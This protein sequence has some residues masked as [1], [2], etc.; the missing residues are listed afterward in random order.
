VQAN[1]VAVLVEPGPQGRPLADQGLVGDLGRPLAEGHEP[2]LGEPLEQRL[3]HLG[4]D[5]VGDELVDVHAPAAFG[6]GVAELREPEEHA[7]RHGAAVGRQGGEHAVGGARDRRGDAA[8]LAVAL[9]GERASV[10]ALPGGAERVREERQR[11]G[12]AGDVAQGQLDQPGLEPQP[13]EAC[14]LSHR[15]LELGVAHRSEQHLV[16]GDRASE[17]RVR[18][19]LA[20]HVGSHADRDRSPDRQQRIDECLPARG[21]VAQREQLLELIDDHKRGRIVGDVEPR[22]PAR[23]DQGSA[24]DAVDFAR[25]HGGDDAGSK[26]R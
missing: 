9:D 3:H 16:G 25:P 18:S 6:C 14:R 19:E 15:S 22:R 2:R 7:A 13:G 11:P 26:Q 23:P 1:A 17:L 20:V 24:C 8:G 21:V 5:R 12:L 4:R 10:A